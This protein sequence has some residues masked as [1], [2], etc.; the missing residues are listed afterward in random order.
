MRGS[1]TAAV[2][3]WAMPRGGP[4]NSDPVSVSLMIGGELPLSAR[5]N[6]A[7]A[8]GWLM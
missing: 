8:Y 3:V 1:F 2:S 4:V 5:K 6:G 7:T